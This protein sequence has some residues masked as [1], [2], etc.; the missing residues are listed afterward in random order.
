MHNGAGRRYF[1]PD[2][3]VTENEVEQLDSIGSPSEFYCGSTR[4]EYQPENRLFCMSFILVVQ[5]LGHYFIFRPQHSSHDVL[6]IVTCS[7]KVFA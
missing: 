1:A 7:L 5:R 4:F 6:I 3:E 2:S